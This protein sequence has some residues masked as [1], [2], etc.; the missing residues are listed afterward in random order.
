ATY[1]FASGYD[2]YVRSTPDKLTQDFLATLPEKW[3]KE[4][5]ELSTS[6]I[7]EDAPSDKELAKRGLAPKVRNVWSLVE[8]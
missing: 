8:N 2:G 6:G 7:N 4:K 1:H 3:R 5:L